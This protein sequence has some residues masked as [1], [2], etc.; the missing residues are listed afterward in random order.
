[1]KKLFLIFTG[2]TYVVLTSACKK[3]ELETNNQLDNSTQES[4]SRIATFASGDSQHTIALNSA[5]DIVEGALNGQ[6]TFFGSNSLEVSTAIA[7]L[8]VELANGSTNQ[9]YVDAYVDAVK[10]IVTNSSN[11]LIVTGNLHHREGSGAYVGMA[12]GWNTPFIKAKFSSAEQNRI[13]LTMKAALVACAYV[14]ADYTSAGVQRPNK[15]V[16]MR[17]D[18]LYS[19]ALKTI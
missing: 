17:G 16:D 19:R 3:T 8:A 18:I 9:T 12:L 15:R 13:L 14:M 1:M 2:L 5:V 11:Q 7:T 4:S 6:Y 10:E